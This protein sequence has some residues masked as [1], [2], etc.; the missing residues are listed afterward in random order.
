MRKSV[1]FLCLVLVLSLLWVPSA[2]SAGF[3]FSD[4]RFQ[5]E[6]TT[7][8]M[9]RIIEEYELYDGWYWT[10]RPY[11]MQ[12]FHGQEDSPGWTDTAVNQKKKNKYRRGFYGCR[13]F[14]NKVS[15]NTPGRGGYGECFGFA[16]FIGYLLS[17]DTNPYTQWNRYYN[18]GDSRGFRVG[19][20]LRADF[21]V[22]GKQYGHSAVVYSVTDE[23]I[24]FIQVS[25]SS[26]DLISIGE[27]FKDGYNDAP[28]T[29]EDLAKISNFKICRSPLND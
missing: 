28:K 22:N 10:T 20:V 29:L 26:Y 4:E 7:E 15:Y 3:L 9:D 17:G 11:V 19:D 2:F 8:N 5:G 16:M 21:T 13:W 27:G 24:T 14:A 25:G 23:E 18:L 12:T 1:R 6:F